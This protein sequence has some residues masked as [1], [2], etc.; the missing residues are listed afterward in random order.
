M[1]IETKSTEERLL[2]EVLEGIGEE[3]NLLPVTKVAKILSMS[4]GSI[5]RLIE[6]GDL[7]TVRPELNGSRGHLRILKSSVINLIKKWYAT[8][9]A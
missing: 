2:E 3:S 7:V 4:R 5:Y 8:T 9:H 1:A 6:R